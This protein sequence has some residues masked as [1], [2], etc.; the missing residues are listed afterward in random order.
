VGLVAAM[1][2]AVLLVRM[3]PSGMT[4]SPSSG[5]IDDDSRSSASSA[6]PR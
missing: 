5:G 6:R 1:V 4:Q 2:F 3:V